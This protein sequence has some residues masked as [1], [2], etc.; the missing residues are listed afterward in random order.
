MRYD[1][2]KVKSKNSGTFKKLFYLTIIGAIL[3][4]VYYFW[5]KASPKQITMQIVKQWTWD[6][7]SIEQR[8]MLELQKK[9]AEPD[10]I[11]SQLPFSK[12]T[13]TNDSI[14]Y[15]Y[16]GSNAIAGIL[17]NG[18]IG[19]IWPAKP[20]SLWDKSLNGAYLLEYFKTGDS[21]SLFT[22][23]GHQVWQR[24][25][26]KYP[27]ISPNANYVLMISADSSVIALFNRF[28]S[29]IFSNLS[30]GLEMT[31]VSW[32]SDEKYLGLS[33]L[34]GSITL[35][36]IPT[37]KYRN[38]RIH[39]G[40]NL[41]SG[42]TPDQYFAIKNIHLSHNGKFVVLHAGTPPGPDILLW[43]QLPQYNKNNKNDPLSPTLLTQIVLD[44]DYPQSLPMEII[45]GD[46]P[47]LLFFQ[48][49]EFFLANTK[50]TFFSLQENIHKSDPTQTLAKADPA[51]YI[52]INNSPKNDL[53]LIFFDGQTLQLYLL[54]KSTQGS[55]SIAYHKKYNQ[56]TYG[57]AIFRNQGNKLLVETNNSMDFFVLYQRK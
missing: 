27:S 50:G 17:E 3:F 39:S 44:K 2:T 19:R 48:K 41:I 51:S 38:I 53:S 52:D 57:R 8:I 28:Q 9:P 13:L 24:Q 18:Q 26:R 34:D 7:S 15:N 20:D 56:S 47:L 4:A 45:D 32:S 46:E 42:F 11:K 33:F 40:E 22:N 25:T 54:Q 30:L 21:V 10:K 55:F 36:H 43:Y 29:Q 35:A 37:K 31:A 14:I 6:F 5:P 12:N 16:I 1:Y 49:K 23:Q